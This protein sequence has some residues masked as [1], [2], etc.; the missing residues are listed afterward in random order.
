M[1]V[2]VCASSPVNPD[3]ERPVLVEQPDQLTLDLPGQH[4]AYD[5]HGVLGGDPK[6]CLELADD[7]VLVEGGADLRAA[8]VH[9]DGLEA[10]LAQEDD[11]LGEGA[12]QL[13]VHHGVSAELDDDDLAVVAGQPGQRF[14]ED[15]GL[16]QR[17][18]LAGSAHDEYALF[19]WT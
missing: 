10:G 14:D 6:A 12:L 4:H 5:V 15:P 17:G 2:M 7:A 1:A 19:S 9:D 11:V 13:L 3:G 16:G 18:V 8:A